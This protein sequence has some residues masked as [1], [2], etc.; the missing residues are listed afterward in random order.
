[1]IST[2]IRKDTR[3]VHRHHDV[4]DKQDQTH[5]NFLINFEI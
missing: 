1:M 4:R 5:Y 2:G 3:H